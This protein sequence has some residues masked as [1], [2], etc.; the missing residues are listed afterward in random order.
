[1]KIATFNVN[2]VNTRLGR[3]VE[4]L[5]GRG[6][7]AYPDEPMYTF[8]ELHVQTLGTRR[9]T[10]CRPQLCGLGKLPSGHRD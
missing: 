4:W 2:G 5:D 10:A 1:M 9:R 6:P 3:L 8:W 7:Q